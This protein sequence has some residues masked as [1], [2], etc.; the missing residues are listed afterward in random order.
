M[1]VR[2]FV[3]TRLSYRERETILTE[4]LNAGEDFRP[5]VTR[6]LMTWV[7]MLYVECRNSATPG[8]LVHMDCRIGILPGLEFAEQFSLA[9]AV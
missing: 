3:H 8:S 2:G 5:Y 1:R 7:V 4:L 6:I 9:G